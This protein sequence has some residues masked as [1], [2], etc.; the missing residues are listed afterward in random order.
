M[1]GTVKFYSRDKG[2]GF[3][4]TDQHDR[5]IYFKISEWKNPSAPNS[6]D[7]VEFETKPGRKGLEAINIKC[8]RSDQQRKQAQR[9]AS[10]ERVTCPS[11][12][13]K[14]VPRI[15]FYH[16]KPQAS[17]CPYCGTKIKDFPACFIATAVYG[18]YDH[19]N[20]RSLRHFRDEQLKKSGLGRSFIAFYY[21]KSPALAEKLKV[22]P[23]VAALVKVVLNTFVFIYNKFNGE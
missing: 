16:G 9:E 18:D 4:F 7:I 1:R 2:Y 13:K 14:M 10:D 20:V 11:C 6:N 23:R 15:S 19:P 5:D 21:K 3:I 8:I 17:F 22:M 12:G